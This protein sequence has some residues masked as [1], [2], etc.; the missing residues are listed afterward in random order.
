ML[1][2]IVVKKKSLESYRP[3]IDEQTLTEIRSVA[4]DLRGL[5][6]LHLLRWGSGRTP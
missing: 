3:V 4:K 6:V 5:R 2:H 1:E